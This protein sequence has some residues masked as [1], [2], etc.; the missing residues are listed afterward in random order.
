MHLG[1][2]H[3]NAYKRTNSLEKTTAK[4]TVTLETNAQVLNG[5]V[6]LV[7][8]V[9]DKLKDNGQEQKLNKLEEIERKLGSFNQVVK[10]TVEPQYSKGDRKKK[11]NFQS[12]KKKENTDRA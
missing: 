5:N 8:E 6:K 4:E 1:F 7:N 2:A 9:V 12:G 10:K 11:D 3:T